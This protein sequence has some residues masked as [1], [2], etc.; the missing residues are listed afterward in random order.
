MPFTAKDA[1]SHTKKASTVSLQ[2]L[3]ARI[4]NRLLRQGASDASA[5]RLANAVIARRGS[6]LSRKTKP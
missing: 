5:I 3:W 4:A 6:G 1:A 2:K